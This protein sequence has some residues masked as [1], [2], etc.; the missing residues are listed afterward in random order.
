L[1]KHALDTIVFKIRKQREKGKEILQMS[2]FNESQIKDLYESNL[3]KAKQ[4]LSTLE[5]YCGKEIKL[6]GLNGWIFEQTIRYCIQKELK[7]QHI[8]LQISEQVSLCG[9]C[10]VDLKVGNIAIEMKSRGLFGQKDIERYRGYR[11]AA[12]N[13]GWRYVV[14]GLNETYEPYRQGIIK[15]LGQDRVFYL[16]RQNGEWQRFID[17]LCASGN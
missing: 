16:F 12:E 8:S 2:L 17:L 9:R 4:L 15:S 6:N 14:V 3:E 13:K 11:K 7:N 1:H 10:K 5:V